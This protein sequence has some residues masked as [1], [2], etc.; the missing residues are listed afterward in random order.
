MVLLCHRIFVHLKLLQT[1]DPFTCDTNDGNCW[2]GMQHEE[3][4]C[5]DSGMQW[6]QT[7]TINEC[8]DCIIS[9]VVSYWE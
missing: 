1:I 6:R 5:R 2:N 3:Q 4:D 7:R 8:E 9:S